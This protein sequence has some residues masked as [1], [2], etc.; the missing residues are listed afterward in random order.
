MKICNNA[1]TKQHIGW[2]TDERF[3]GCPVFWKLIHLTSGRILWRWIS[4]LPRFRYRKWEVSVVSRFLSFRFDGIYSDG[5]VLK[6]DAWMITCVYSTN[7][8]KINVFNNPG[9]GIWLKAPTVSWTL[10]CSEILYSLE[11][12]SE[13]VE[14]YIYNKFPKHPRWQNID[15]FLFTICLLQEVNLMKPVLGLATAALRGSRLRGVPLMQLLNG[16]RAC[17]LS[18][19]SER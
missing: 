13:Y 11:T 4:T 3:F 16:Q 12:V 19:T 15:R 14:W 1:L 5:I 2:K 10:Y 17:L 9:C 6:K 7:S 18:F 8:P